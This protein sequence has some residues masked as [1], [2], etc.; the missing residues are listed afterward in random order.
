[1][2]NLHVLTNVSELL[3][4]TSLFHDTLKDWFCVAECESL[5]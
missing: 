2:L 3:E 1:M 5:P 4:L